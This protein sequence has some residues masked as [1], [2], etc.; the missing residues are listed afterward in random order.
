MRSLKSYRYWGN[1]LYKS[2]YKVS[3]A[4]TSCRRLLTSEELE[5]DDQFFWE[6]VFGTS[7]REKITIGKATA[8]VFLT[9][10]VEIELLHKKCLPAHPSPS[11]SGGERPNKVQKPNE[12]AP[13]KAA[14]K[15]T[16]TSKPKTSNRIHSRRERGLETVL[17]IRL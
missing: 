3:L 17:R 12:K 6:N 1:A 4:K 5:S 9:H 15:E 14:Q 8:Q 13:S 11:P 7:S 2:G 16:T 10:R